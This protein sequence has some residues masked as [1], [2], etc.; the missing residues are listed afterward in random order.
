MMVKKY[1][2]DASEEIVSTSIPQILSGNG[3]VSMIPIAREEEVE[4]EA[5]AA[6]EEAMPTHRGV[7]HPACFRK[8]QI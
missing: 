4:V 2:V 7:T 5:V 3:R 8:E 6:R 1:E